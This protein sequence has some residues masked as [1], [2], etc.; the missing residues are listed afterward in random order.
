MLSKSPINLALKILSAQYR[1]ALGESVTEADVEE[2]R[3]WAGAEGESISARDAACRV[4]QMEL[5]R[6]GKDRIQ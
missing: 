3:K 2:I 4:I 1:E 5:F 6:E